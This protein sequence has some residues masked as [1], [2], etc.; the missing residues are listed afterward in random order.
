[1]NTQNS[2]KFGERLREFPVFLL[3]FLAVTL[4]L[5]CLKVAVMVAG[6][7]PSPDTLFQTGPSR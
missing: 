2:K 7:A 1:M 6:D 3:Y 4:M 5:T